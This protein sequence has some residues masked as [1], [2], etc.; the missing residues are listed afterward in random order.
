M[1]ELRVEKM[2]ACA[3]RLTDYDGPC[4]RL[5]GHNYKIEVAYTG[6][7]LDRSGLLVDFGD[8]KKALNAILDEL[9]HRFLN[10]L[11]AFAGISPSAENIARYIY[12]ELEKTTFDRATLASVAVWETP[13]QYA[14]Y[15]QP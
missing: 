12:T 1:F 5:H 13:N 9:D 4:E 7:E 8:I 3:H 14:I 15:R 10:E 11:P 2:M 6:T